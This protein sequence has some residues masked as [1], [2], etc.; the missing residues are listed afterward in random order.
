MSVMPVSDTRI[1]EIVGYCLPVVW[2][3]QP[4]LCC[5]G[6]CPTQSQVPIQRNKRSWRN[7]SSTQT[8]R[9]CVVSLVASVVYVAYF[10]AFVAYVGLRLKPGRV[11]L[12]IRL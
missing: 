6:R 8:F 1:I 12:S 10:R 7:A 11:Q 9:P 4:R 2:R 3:C 5:P